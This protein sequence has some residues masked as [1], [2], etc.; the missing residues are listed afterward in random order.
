M[1]NEI[2]FTAFITD[3]ELDN[4]DNI[5]LAGRDIR[6]VNSWNYSG[7][8]TKL[9]ANYNETWEA[10]MT[11]SDV[12]LW[13]VEYDSINDL[14]H[15]SGSGT[16]VNYNPLG[17]AYTLANP[18]TQGTFFASYNTQGIMQSV[19]LFANSSVNT[20]DQRMSMSIMEGRLLLSGYFN[21][22]PDL[23]LIHISEP[24]RPY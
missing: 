2:P 9:D 6:Y 20:V 19:H 10:L 1:V 12:W 18:E 11:G 14:I 16:G 17:E 23:S 4:N 3:I 5:Y 13:N 8:L 21:G 7:I 24:T 15:I 22:Y